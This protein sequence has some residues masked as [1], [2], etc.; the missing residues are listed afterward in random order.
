[1]RLPGISQAG[2]YFRVCCWRAVVR[3]AVTG[4]NLRHRE[5]EDDGQHRDDP[6]PDQQQEP[7]VHGG[8]LQRLHYVAQQPHDV[9][10]SSGF[11]RVPRMAPAAVRSGVMPWPVRI[12]AASMVGLVAGLALS[13]ASTMYNLTHWDSLGVAGAAR[14]GSMHGAA[15]E[16]VTRLIDITGLV[17]AGLTVVVLTASVR[18]ML[19]SRRW[20]YLVTGT[21][22]VV[23]AITCAG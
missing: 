9:R 22:A 8:R 4:A 17:F 20:G 11:R 1:M 6:D 15:S 12:A 13:S 5:H 7:A 2:P 3:L 14:D 10:R 18:A 16:H 21:V 23:Y 19:R